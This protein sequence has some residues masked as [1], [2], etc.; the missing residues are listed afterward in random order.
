MIDK[1]NLYTKNYKVRKDNKLNKHLIQYNNSKRWL[2]THKD[3]KFSIGKNKFQF[4]INIKYNE[5]FINLLPSKFYTKIN[6]PLLNNQHK[7][8]GILRKV[9]QGCKEIGVEFNYQNL[10]ICALD[11]AKDIEI[12]FPYSAYNNLL[13][14]LSGKRLNSNKHYDTWYFENKSRGFVFYNKSAQ[15]KDKFDFNINKD[16]IR[17]ELRFKSKK[18]VERD[19]NIHY[20]TEFFKKNI[21][22]RLNRVFEK[23]LEKLIFFDCCE[24]DKQHTKEL[25]IL[26]S[27]INQHKSGGINRFV[28]DLGINY[29]TKNGW[30]IDTL[31]DILKSSGLKASTVTYH[32]KKMIKSMKTGKFNSDDSPT[33][34]YQELRKKLIG[35]K[36]KNEIKKK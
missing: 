9:Q 25:E 27:Y 16:I 30:E 20:A 24:D 29:L 4:S 15:L 3:Y 5:L 23:W 8:C 22:K 10:S 31:L 33:S 12:D 21:F 6:Y 14:N 32:K 19:T 34:L 13:N 2:K 28:Y 18:I 11:I 7:L 36:T 1:L 17:V 35:G 26:K